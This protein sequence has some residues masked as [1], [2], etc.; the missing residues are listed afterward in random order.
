MVTP[1]SMAEAAPSQV[2]AQRPVFVGLPSGARMA[3]RPAHTSS[4]GALVVP[5][6]I[7]KAGWWTGGSRLGDPYGSI[8]VAAH[9]DSFTQGVGHFAELLQV[10]PGDRVRLTSRDLHQQFRVVWAQ[11]VP[12]SSLADGAG[13]FTPMGDGRLVLVTCGGAFDP[14]RDGYQDNMVVV[15]EPVGAPQPLNR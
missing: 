5:D 11:L 4:T 1:A 2:V 12:K 8:V 15:A 3:V 6:D 10:S 14:S 13:A 9:V 7:G